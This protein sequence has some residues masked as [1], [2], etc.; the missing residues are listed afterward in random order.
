[1]DK[2]ALVLFCYLIKPCR[3]SLP[4][5]QHWFMADGL[6]PPGD[7]QH[8]SFPLLKHLLRPTTQYS[9]SAPLPLGTHYF[10]VGG[11]P[12]CKVSAKSPDIHSH[13]PLAQIKAICYVYYDYSLN[14]FNFKH[15]YSLPFLSGP[16]A[17]HPEGR[18]KHSGVLTG[19]AEQLL[20]PLGDQPVSEGRIRGSVWSHSGEGSTNPVCECNGSRAGPQ[21]THPSLKYHTGLCFSLYKSHKGYR[22]GRESLLSGTSNALHHWEKTPRA[23]LERSQHLCVLTPQQWILVQETLPRQN[24]KI[25]QTQ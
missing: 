1:M 14:H 10:R 2:L 3:L 9:P 20:V 8:P 24:Q 11:I 19:R 17:E 6:S 7:L 25:K 21:M 16:S 4:H 15:P 23:A 5:S 13:F 18:L 22:S 12:P